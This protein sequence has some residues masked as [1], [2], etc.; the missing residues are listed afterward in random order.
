MPN[1]IKFGSLRQLLLEVGFKEF[2]RPDEIIFRHAPSDTLFVF[3]TYQPGDAVAGYNLIE[4]K[5]MLDSRG[6]M[7]G[8][9][10]ERQFEKT[11]A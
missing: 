3:R 1:K 5:D 9:S 2:S 6:L 4:V 7:S 10:F 8:E 11:P